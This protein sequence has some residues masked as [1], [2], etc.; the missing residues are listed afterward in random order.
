MTG[1]S[2]RSD[3][4][5]QTLPHL[6]GG[7][8]GLLLADSV[9]GSLVVTLGLVLLAKSNIIGTQLVFDSDKVICHVRALDLI[10][11]EETLNI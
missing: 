11:Y 4:V 3:L 2:D 6:S 7:F 5:L 1:S 10:L 8:G 9:A